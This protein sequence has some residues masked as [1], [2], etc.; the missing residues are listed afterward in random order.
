[1]NKHVKRTI[2]FCL[3]I[4]M[5]SGLFACSRDGGEVDES[6]TEYTTLNYT[7][8]GTVE[9]PVTGEEVVSDTQNETQ[10]FTNPVR[11]N[12]ESQI[13]A[14]TTMVIK[15]TQTN[16]KVEETKPAE[17]KKTV[18][19]TIPAGATMVDVFAIL[20]ANGVASF[21]SLMNTAQNFDFTYYPLIA[22]QK[23]SLRAFKLEGYLRPGTYSFKENSKPEDAIGRL[24]RSMES[25]ITA[26]MRKQIANK[27]YTADDIVTIASIIQMEC[28]DTS[29]MTRVSAV[30]HNRLAQGMKLELP[31]TIAYVNT[32]VKPYLLTE[33]TTVLNQYDAR[34]DTTVCAALPAS[35]ICCPGSD[36]ITAALNPAGV[37]YLYFC[38]DG[39]GNYLYASTLEE[40]EANLVAAGLMQPSVPE[41]N[42]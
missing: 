17:I 26:S 10:G 15:E 38:V 29:N 13:N 24:L 8:P 32:A 16:P 9:V 19:V 39:E 11:P 25:S 36:A 40:H 34:Y 22:D 28:S 1:M 23:S 31:S 35:P 41:E 14:A 2:C 42:S 7:Y 6:T 33:D 12:I 30:I 5:M 18:T 27:G 21:S 20:D 4:F 37:D 3:A